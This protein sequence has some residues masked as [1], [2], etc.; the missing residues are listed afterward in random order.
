MFS[1][2]KTISN[3]SSYV[4]KISWVKKDV[5]YGYPIWDSEYPNWD[6]CMMENRVLNTQEY[7][8]CKCLYFFRWK[9]HQTNWLSTTRPAV[10]IWREFSMTKKYLSFLKSQ[11][12]FERDGN[13]L[14][15]CASEL[16]R[17]WQVSCRWKN[18]TQ[19][20]D[21]PIYPVVVMFC[22]N[23]PSQIGYS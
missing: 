8:V 16:N 10:N 3:C 14:C 6:T 20:E 13:W 4:I 5:P 21:T 18:K 7:S 17:C 23:L 22:T 11:K 1:E 9:I 2:Q 19:N 12:P 15:K